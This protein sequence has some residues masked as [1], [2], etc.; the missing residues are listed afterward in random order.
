MPGIFKTL[1]DEEKRDINKEAT[2]MA[3]LEKK[4]RP[5]ILQLPKAIRTDNNFILPP[6]PEKNCSTPEVDKYING[7]LSPYHAADGTMFFKFKTGAIFKLGET[8]VPGAQGKVCSGQ[9]ITPNHTRS[10]P[11]VKKTGGET[12][13]REIELLRAIKENSNKDFPFHLIQ[14]GWPIEAV[15]MR[16][17]SRHEKGGDLQQHQVNIQ[18][19]CQ[20]K[21]PNALSYVFDV[22][23]QLTE[24]LSALHNGKFTDLEGKL[25]AGVVHNDLK[26]AN[27]F[28]RT[29]GDVVIA[30]FG[31]AYFADD[32]APQYA[33][34]YF[35]APELFLASTEFCIVSSINATKSDIFSLGLT[36]T[37]LLQCNLPEKRV[38]GG[39]VLPRQLPDTLDTQL[40]YRNWAETYE[41]SAQCEEARQAKK[42]LLALEKDAFAPANP[43]MQA[44][45][46]KNFAL[47]MQLPVDE[48]PTSQ[49]LKKRMANLACYFG[50]PELRA[51]NAKI[52]ASTLVENREKAKE[53]AADCENSGKRKETADNEN[54]AKR[55]CR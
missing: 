24:G 34:I 45:I 7:T 29:N 11:L 46:L 48:R 55:F 1:D 6:T 54:G 23:S 30:D 9:A 22:M 26:P 16:H 44:E 12:I 25:H 49:E 27:I 35:A 51:E 50:T 53:K 14:Q 41:N 52:F 2:R 40:K 32:I 15:D 4:P 38:A 36:L 39:Y 21:N 43:T 3:L 18:Q 13:K 47:V 42:Y 17:F 5:T 28:V 37:L 33:T 10:Y 19:Q 8:L 31:C 20:S